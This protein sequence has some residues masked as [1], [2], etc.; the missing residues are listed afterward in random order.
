VQ[1]VV[2]RAATEEQCTVRLTHPL[3]HPGAHGFVVTGRRPSALREA[4][5]GVLIRSTGTLHYAVQRDVVDDDDLHLV[6]LLIMRATS[7]TASWAMFMMAT[8]A[9]SRS[10][11]R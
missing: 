9:E 1:D 7:L 8:P 3:R 4:M 2:V 6:F 10:N 5:P 11:W